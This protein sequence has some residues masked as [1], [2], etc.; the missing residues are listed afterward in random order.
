MR[1]L[2]TASLVLALLAPDIARADAIERGFILRIED[3][4]IYFNIGKD[5]GVSQGARLRIKRPIKLKHPVTG[6]MIADW[7]PVGSA[8]VTAVAE[9]L[10]MA[11]LD[12]DL[13]AAVAVGDVIESLVLTDV[14]LPVPELAE[15]EAQ[16]GAP[17]A[18]PGEP[19]PAPDAATQA[20][21][22][23]WR[24]TTGRALEVRIGAWEDFLTRNPDSPYAAVV[25]EDVEVLRQHRDKLRPAELALDEALS[26][27]LSHDAPTRARPNEPVDLLF[28]IDLPDLAAAWL[29]YRVRGTSSYS[30][31]MLRR[32]GNEYV[33]GRVPAS[34]VQGPGLEYFVEIV[35]QR[36]A[37]GAAV[38]SPDDPVVIA[39]PS[40]PLTSVFSQRQNRSRVSLTTTYLDFATFD[41]RAGDH[42][43]VFYMAEADFL[44]RLRGI[45]YGIRTGFGVLSG[46]GGFTN[47][48]YETPAD[49]PKAGFNY[50]FAELELRGGYRTAF[51]AR[52]VAGVGRE[53]FGLGSE[54]RF[55]LGDEDGTNLS[56][57]VSSLAQIG[58]LTEMRM[59][60]DAMPGIPL[61]LAVA[62][63]DQPSRGDLGVR[64]TTDIG[65]RALPWM[66]PT[67]RIS[68]QAR[69]V[70]HSGIGAGLGLVFDW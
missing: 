55:R 17:E 29:H 54:G 49:R 41:G 8:T 26:G 12:P 13:L 53:G 65:Y 47:V 52:L 39:V 21:L 4:E 25:S 43:D 3:R 37:V 35:T 66:H 64:L 14:P 34:A 6:Q 28:L 7:L 58:F 23:V 10:S 68:Y 16:P 38:G 5:R 11:V 57:G 48:A 15:P 32:D 36:G 9:S 31:G 44:Y 22:A 60:W 40:P 63:T 59:Q 46:T 51:L 24:A 56:L 20:V 67:L 70:V 45:L 19:L 1:H 33:R 2:I 30:K 27:G 69:T 18:Q 42:T 62:L 50:G 61:G